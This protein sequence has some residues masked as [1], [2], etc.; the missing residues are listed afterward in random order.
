LLLGLLYYT[1]LTSQ[2]FDCIQYYY[3]DGRADG[4]FTFVWHQLT[5][6]YKLLRATSV[7]A[8]WFTYVKPQFH[9]FDVFYLFSL[10]F[11]YT[12]AVGFDEF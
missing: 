3:Y 10:I 7:K 9:Q 8:I 6:L 11:E 1:N 2:H 4:N 12:A 5:D